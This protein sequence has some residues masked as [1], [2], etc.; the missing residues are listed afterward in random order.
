MKELFYNALVGGS[1]KPFDTVLIYTESPKLGIE[2]DYEEITI[3]DVDMSIPD[4]VLIK[5]R[6]NTGSSEGKKYWAN[7]SEVFEGY[8]VF[9][10]LNNRIRENKMILS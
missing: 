8:Y 3:L 1:V 4:Q 5:Y 7:A 10:V 2:Y 9:S 6:I